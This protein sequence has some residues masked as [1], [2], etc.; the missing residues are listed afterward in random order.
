MTLS[1]FTTKFRYE[2][3]G[4][5]SSFSYPTKVFDETYIVVK[6]VDRD[7][8]ADIETLALTT[9]YTVT[10]SS[11]GTGTVTITNGTKI[12]A[13]DEDIVI[14]Q[15]IPVTQDTALPSGTAFP[16][17]TIETALD[18]LTAIVQVLKD[19]LGRAITI[20]D[21]EI[22]GTYDLEVPADRALKFLA[23]DANKNLVATSGTGT[24]AP[25]STAM[26]PV[27]AAASTADA[28]TLLGAATQADVDLKAPIDNAELTGTLT[29]NGADVAVDDDVKFL[30]KAVAG[31]LYGLT[32][33]YNSTDRIDVSSGHAADSTGA[34]PIVLGSALTA[35][36][37]QLSGAWAAGSTAN[38]LDAG[39]KA[40]STCYHVF[41][42]LKNDYTEDVLFSLSATSPTLPTDYTHFRRIGSIFT[43]G[44]G[45]IRPFIQDGDNFLYKTNVKDVNSVTLGTTPTNYTLTTPSGVRTVAVASVGIFKTS[46]NPAVYVYQPELTDAGYTAAATRG[47]S[48][49]TGYNRVQI[50]TNTSAQIRAYASDTGCTFIV[51]TVGYI[52][53]RG[54]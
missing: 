37:L 48:G 6:L 51:D 20:S 53:T 49:N 44:S 40:N 9:D 38:K 18:K 16:S 54:K 1:A 7:T 13:S 23:F 8:S 47:L 27:V 11:L 46:L 25:I 26:E 32:L 24:T 30:A 41:V 10:I 4:S 5:T 34:E 45:N 2:G 39:A 52:D 17:S 14:D 50:L 42:I 43:D 22:A 31:S 3:N 15:L 33:S 28:R 21:N 35:C 19:Q 12:P 36:I 29:L